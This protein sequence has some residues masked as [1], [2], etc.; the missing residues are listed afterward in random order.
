[1]SRRDSGVD[2][3]GLLRARERNFEKFLQTH[4]FSHFCASA[5]FQALNPASLPSWHCHSREGA[6][7]ERGAGPLGWVWGIPP[8]SFSP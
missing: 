6:G 4:S 8:P 5:S 2:S 1:M 3:W 7:E